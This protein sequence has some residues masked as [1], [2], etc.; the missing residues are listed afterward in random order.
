MELT[1]RNKLLLAVAALGVV[2]VGVDQ[3]FFGAGREQIVRSGDDAEQQATSTSAVATARV[4]AFNPAA[5]AVGEQ[6]DRLVTNG[7]VVLNPNQTADM[8]RAPAAW[9][10]EAHKPAALSA[11]GQSEG[12]SALD[13]QLASAFKLSSVALKPN[14]TAVVNGVLLREGRS[15]SITVAGR[16]Q[17]VKLLSVIGPDRATGS[18]GGAVLQVGRQQVRVQIAQSAQAGIE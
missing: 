16:K 14:A 4:V 5:K 12:S 9:F 10:G 17:L 6:L 7:D 15:V 18:A 13:Q 1:Q 11:R 8:F 2:A 3:V